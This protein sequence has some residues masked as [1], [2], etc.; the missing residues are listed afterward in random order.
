MVL[1]NGEDHNGI[2]QGINPS[3][4]TINTTN[5]NNNLQ[6]STVPKGILAPLSHPTMNDIDW[7]STSSI[8]DSNTDLP[9]LNATTALVKKFQSRK[10]QLQHPSKRKALT[11]PKAR[12]AFLTKLWNMV[13]TEEYRDYI[14]WMDDG[15]SFQVVNKDQFEK[16]ILPKFFKHQNFSSFVRQ[17]NM[18]GWHKVQD[19]T[20]GA[21]H[22]NEEVWQFESPNFIRGR[23][24]LLDNIVRNKSNS[25]NEFDG[26]ITYGN[27]E[28]FEEEE[29]DFQIILNELETIRK[30]QVAISEDL[31]SV[32]KDNDMLWKEYYL[33][34]EKHKSHSETLDR[35]LRF[36]AS[37]Y[38]NQSKILEVDSSD[39]RGLSKFNMNDIANPRGGGQSAQQLLLTHGG[40]DD[41]S[42]TSPI[43]EIN[44][45]PPSEISSVT[46]TPGTSNIN[47][48]GRHYSITPGSSSHIPHINST[49]SIPM[50]TIPD[51]SAV[52]N[53]PTD[54]SHDGFLYEP[55]FPS[56]VDQ[57]TD[58]PRSLF[59]ELHHN[60]IDTPSPTNHNNNNALRTQPQLHSSYP[61]IQSIPT[62]PNPKN[63][64]KAKS[65]P[66]QN[67][68]SPPLGIPNSNSNNNNNSLA[69]APF[70]PS[71]PQERIDKLSENDQFLENLSKNIDMQGKSIQQVSNWLA[72]LGPLL[73]NADIYNDDVQS[74]P[75]NQISSNITVPVA[76]D[77]QKLFDEYLTPNIEGGLNNNNISTTNP[78][79]NNDI[80]GESN[81]Y[82]DTTEDK[83]GNNNSSNN[84]TKR[85]IEDDVIEEIRGDDA[86]EDEYYTNGQGLKK[87]KL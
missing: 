26:G 53:S 47:H 55:S 23:E 58:S 17:L 9:Q 52:I 70:S 37:L 71:I 78:M 42:N 7:N 3:A 2:N 73:S 74:D 32:R 57:L 40:N 36:L 5:N 86:D 66:L 84:H 82:M 87:M 79:N 20:A 28:N 25:K 54:L 27:N 77:E 45:I 35:I 1:D 30:N 81:I 63:N 11:G 46:A 6:L 48:N 12:P 22:S 68:N 39:S 44:S 34:R 43:L 69:L 83:N 10:Q 76:S 60:N 59:P 18:Y 31:R 21:M 15:K 61:N 65:T 72:D 80:N 85:A 41:Y 67:L 75:Q 62:T 64:S 49:S 50:T 19:V 29:M 51:A 13:N 8:A 33:S 38:G 14:Q 24:D 16:I 4:N 56:Y